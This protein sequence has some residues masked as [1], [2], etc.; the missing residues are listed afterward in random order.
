M[1]LAPGVGKCCCV[2]GPY[3]L[4]RECHCKKW[5]LSK[6]YIKGVDATIEAQML[7]FTFLS[8]QLWS[9]FGAE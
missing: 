5:Q 7:L 1:S 3:T 6:Q 2:H 4:M 9:V 8:T